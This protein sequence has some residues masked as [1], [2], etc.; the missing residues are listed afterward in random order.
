M[1]D[2]DSDFGE[3]DFVSSASTVVNR[4]WSKQNLSDIRHSVESFDGLDVTT[5]LS[6]KMKD[7]CPP[8]SFK[9]NTKEKNSDIKVQVTPPSSPETGKSNSNGKRPKVVRGAARTR[10]T[11]QALKKIE[12]KNQPFAVESNRKLSH[13]EP[14]TFEMLKPEAQMNES[15][16]I[17]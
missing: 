10:K 11:T 3:V 15:I 12:Q 2:S 16:E 8:D 4:K 14:I 1:S 6:S 5:D 13:S 17:Y 9:A 7:Y